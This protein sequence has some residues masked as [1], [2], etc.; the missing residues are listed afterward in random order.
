[1]F[2][3]LAHP[4]RARASRRRGTAILLTVFSLILLLM[5]A[6]LAFMMYAAKEKALAERY[7]EAASTSVRLAPDPTSAANKF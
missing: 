2:R 4:T 5:V 3:P 1:M 7:K 6:G